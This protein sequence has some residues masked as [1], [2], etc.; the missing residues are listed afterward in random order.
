[1]SFGGK[2]PSLEDK[3]WRKT[4]FGG[5]HPLVEDTFGGRQPSMED[6][7]SWILACC[8]VRFEAF[9]D[10]VGEHSAPSRCQTSYTKVNILSTKFL[11]A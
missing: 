5:R 1:M 3:L 8:L 7:I 9:F 2:Q 4:T 10:I 11:L 6:D